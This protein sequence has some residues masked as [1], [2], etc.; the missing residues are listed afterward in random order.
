MKRTVFANAEQ[1]E[2]PVDSYSSMFT[3]DALRS[4]LPLD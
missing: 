4:P 2:N 3:I 1:I